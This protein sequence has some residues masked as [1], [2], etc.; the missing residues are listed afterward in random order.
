MFS[1]DL[2]SDLIILH[3]I[4]SCDGIMHEAKDHFNGE[5]LNVLYTISS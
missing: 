5:N 4:S 1:M 2:S 3:T